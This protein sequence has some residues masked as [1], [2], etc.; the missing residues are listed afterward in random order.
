M[1][2]KSELVA[3]LRECRE[4]VRG[5]ANAKAMDLSSRIDA[6]LAEPEAG[7]TVRVSI[8]VFVGSNGEWSLDGLTSYVPVARYNVTADVPIPQAVEVE[9]EVISE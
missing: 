9:G 7:K 6:A 1:A 3:L 4:F 5:P 8:P 2:I